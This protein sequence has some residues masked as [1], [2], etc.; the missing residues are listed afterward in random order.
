[1]ERDLLSTRENIALQNAQREHHKIKPNTLISNGLESPASF[2][3]LPRTPH[4]AIG[5]IPARRPFSDFNLSSFPASL[6][7]PISEASLAAT[8]CA[9]L[10]ITPAAYHRIAVHG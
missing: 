7:G 4:L 10:L 5:S 9:I 6:S 2:F 1:M 8:V 3:A